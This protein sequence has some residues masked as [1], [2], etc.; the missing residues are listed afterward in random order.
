MSVF[1]SSSKVFSDVSS[2]VSLG[3]SGGGGAGA[4]R[5]EPDFSLACSSLDQYG[6]SI[7]TGKKKTFFSPSIS[8]I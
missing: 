7:N 1:Y 2:E 5:R 8:S 6:G 3:S 4:S